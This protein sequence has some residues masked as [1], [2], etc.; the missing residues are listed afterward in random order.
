MRDFEDG[1]R[2]HG[3]AAQ[4]ELA[5]G[6]GGAENGVGRD[7]PPVRESDR[8]AALKGAALWPGRDAERVGLVNV[9]AARPGVLDERVPDRR[10]AVGN[11]KGDEVVVASLED[12]AGAQ[13]GQVHRVTELA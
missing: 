3:V 5:S 11:A 8:I 12:V 13:L 7:R 6:T 1:R 4:D 10:D 9:E 2:R